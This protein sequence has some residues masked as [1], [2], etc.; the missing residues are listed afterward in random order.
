MG[1]APM[2]EKSETF[3]TRA[4]DELYRQFFVAYSRPQE[5]LVLVGLNASLPG[6]NVHNV[7]TG[8]RRSRDCPWRNNRPFILI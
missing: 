2:D 6:R 1:A 3:P 5:A 4:K 8:W 7:A